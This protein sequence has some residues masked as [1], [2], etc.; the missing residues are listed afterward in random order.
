MIQF[1]IEDKE[2]NLIDSWDEFKLDK[3]IQFAKLE[4]TKEL[5]PSDDLY[6]IKLFE[7]LSGAGDGE[8]DELDMK[9][10]RELEQSGLVFLSNLPPLSEEQ[11]IVIDGEDY[12]FERDISS[13]LTLGAYASV[14]TLIDS[15]DDLLNVFSKIVAILL[16]KAT[17]VDGVWKQEKF[18]ASKIDEQALFLESRLRA[19]DIMG[20]TNFFLGGKQ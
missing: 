3:Y 8:L 5:Y 17:L 19:I 6:M 18:D 12:W 2:F 20:H 9:T 11:H 4:K 14:R 13:K 7:I 16:R 10:Y 15:S 1:K